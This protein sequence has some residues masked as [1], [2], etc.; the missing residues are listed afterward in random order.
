MELSPAD[1]ADGRYAP[2]GHP[3]IRRWIDDWSGTPDHVD[4]L[5][6]HTTAG[7]WLA[8]SRL[9][10][11][12]FV[13]VRGCVIWERAYNPRVFDEWFR[14]LDGDVVG[15][16]AVLNRFVTGDHVTVDDT[17]EGDTVLREVA[18]TVAMCW[19]AALRN[20]FPRQE[21]AVRV[22]DTDDGPVAG[23]TSIPG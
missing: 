3:E 18:G 16:E 5:D 8:F 6:F 1:R 23:F 10:R 12:E 19:D 14:H 7:Q 2:D 13:P 9:L 11:P 21:F 22:Q 15:V 20:A 17:P 4:F